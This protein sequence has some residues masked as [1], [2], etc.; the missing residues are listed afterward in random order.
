MT[1]MNFFANNISG[2]DD[3]R[4]SEEI[5]RDPSLIATSS[6]IDAVGDGSIAQAISDIQFESCVQDNTIS[7]FYNGL[8]SN[9][10]N[11]VQEAQFMRRSQEMVVQNLENQR[12]SISG[13]S[14]DEEMTKLIEYEQA[15]QAAA[16]MIATV[17]EMVQTVLNMI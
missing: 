12:D 1:G 14:L 5:F 6:T 15:Y 7:D 9:I 3:F 16:R 2:A 4:V 10:G 11:R 13:V 17:D 8:I